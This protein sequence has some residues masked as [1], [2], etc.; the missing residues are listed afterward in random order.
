[1]SYAFTKVTTTTDSGN[2]VTS[3]LSL[4]KVISVSH[5]ND[6]ED[7]QEENNSGFVVASND[8][9]SFGTG[10]HV[11]LSD[12]TSMVVDETPEE[13][14]NSVVFVHRPSLTFADGTTGRA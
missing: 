14:F 11:V 10:T 9:D 1:M 13:V 4:D 8:I 6:N 2:K 3:W 12:G 5:L 7:I